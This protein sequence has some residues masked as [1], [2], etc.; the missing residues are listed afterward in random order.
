MEYKSNIESFET[1]GW[2]DPKD[3]TSIKAIDWYKEIT[4]EKPIYPEHLINERKPPA[5][6]FVPSEMLLRSMIEATIEYSDV[7]E[8]LR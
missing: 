3:P 7:Y 6:V 4:F 5:C 2:T 8:L 1:V